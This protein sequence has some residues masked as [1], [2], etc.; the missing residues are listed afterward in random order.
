MIH[1][2]LY[3]VPG[4]YEKFAE[5]QE[6]MKVILDT[7]QSVPGVSRVFR[8]EELVNKELRDPLARQ[9]AASYYPGR[10]GEI[11][12][13]PRPNWVTWTLDADHGSGYPYDVQVPLILMGTG[14]EGGE[15]LAAV[16]ITD[17]APT[18]AYIAGVH[19][20]EVDGR[21]LEEALA[22]GNGKP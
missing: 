12:V 4:V 7:L 15:Y 3:F 14:I 2:D 21:V 6:A 17:I 22:S 13:I 18:L 10:S 8:K 9:V 11:V 19:L 20:E 5:N 1:T 16:E